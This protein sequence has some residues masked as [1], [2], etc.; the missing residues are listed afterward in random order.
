MDKEYIYTGLLGYTSNIEENY[1]IGI[2]GEI[3]AEKIS[4]DIGY[5]FNASI[6]FYFS[7]K[8]MSEDE[9]I[10]AFLETLYGHTEADY[11]V[12]W[13]EITGYLWTDEEL[14]I[15]GHDLLEIFRHNLGK[16]LYLKIVVHEED[17]NE[18]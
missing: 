16:Y 8:R 4:E 10:L 18:D 3:L 15:G 11:G 14:K 13:D 9:L 6:S 5:H 7:D 1:L 12:A 17:T 2:D